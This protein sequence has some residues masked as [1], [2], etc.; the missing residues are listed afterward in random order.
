MEPAQRAAAP[1]DGE[2]L[3]AY[4]AAVVRVVERVGP[5]VVSIHQSKDPGGRQGSGS[6]VVF[7]PDGY[8]LTNAHV[9]GPDPKCGVGRDDRARSLNVTLTDGASHSARV[10]GVH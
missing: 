2:L 3:D 1:D 4:S 9:L 5:A 8:I 6:G 10:V 7:T